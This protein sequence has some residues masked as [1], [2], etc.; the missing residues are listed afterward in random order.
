MA[1]RTNHCTKYIIDGVDYRDICKRNNISETCFYSRVC[2]L[3][4][5][6]EDACVIPSVK[7]RQPLL[8]IVR[9]RKT[10]KEIR[11]AASKQTTTLTDSGARLYCYDLA[12]IALEAQK[13][14]L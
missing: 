4:I 9:L 7:N 5:P 8:E 10:L 11:D 6:P 14:Y 1:N 3:G 13:D 12:R 2:T